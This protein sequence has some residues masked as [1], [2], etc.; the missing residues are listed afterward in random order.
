MVERTARIESG[1]D[2]L[3]RGDWKRA[4]KLFAAA[5]EDAEALEGLGLAA[6]WLDDE[7]ALDARERAY[8]LYRRG[9]DARAAG[10]IA[11]WL[12]WDY[13]TFRGEHAIANGWL[14][15]ARRLLGGLEACPEQG[16]LALREASMVLG[17][18]SERA[19]ALTTGAVELGRTLQDFDLEMTALALDG[20]VRVSR[21]EVAAGMAQLDE[22]TAA[23]VGGEFHDVNAIGL[24]CC[25]LI[26]ACERTQ[27]F[28]RAGQW[29]ERLAQLP[30]AQGN[31]ALSAVCRAH[32]GSVLALRGSWPEAERELVGAADTLAATRPGDAADGLARLGELRRRQGRLDEAEALF[33][34]AE[35]HPIARLGEAALAL[36]RGVPLEAAEAAAAVA[37]RYGGPLR[38]ER[39]AAL[40]LLARALAA[41][42]EIDDA[43]ACAG[44]LEQLARLARS[45]PLRAS[46][47]F[48]RGAIALA[49]GDPD[50]ARRLCTTA[51]DLYTESHLP[52]EAAHARLELA[53]ALAALGRAD[54]AASETRRARDALAALGVTGRRRGDGSLT[55]RELEVLRLVGAGLSDGE[56]AERLVLSE[57]TVHR[58]VAN[59]RTKLGVSSRAAAAAKAARTGLL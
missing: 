20:L 55:T 56:I 33:R 34:K 17:D 25:Y 38:L 50:G 35:P 23:A 30:P 31:R 44:E 49:A 19:H 39:A 1:W 59:I 12:A 32:Y 21:G 9:G 51:V 54:A 7:A 57:H 6:W 40:E 28:D 13:N 5:G 29:C 22:A 47:A 41:L 24:S 53:A 14:Q 16:W 46:A 26:F 58:H 45:D 10:R 37:E 15:R 18:D 3:S 4:R 52:F 43:A 36:E 11:T 2:A 48:A 8:R 42:G 27:D